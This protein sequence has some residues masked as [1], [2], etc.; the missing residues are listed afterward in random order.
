MITVG[1]IVFGVACLL[2]AF[3]L[4]LPIA[5]RLNLPYTVALALLGVIL[6]FVLLQAS[7]PLVQGDLFTSL[8]MLRL[9]ADG[10]LFVFLPPLLFA[11]GLNIDVRRMLDEIGPIILLAVIAVVLCTVI[12][13]VGVVY[14]SGF[15]LVV[16]LLLGAIVATTDSAAVLAIFK[17]L[18]VP[19]RLLVL[20]EGESLFNDAAAIALYTVLFTTLTSPVQP[21]LVDGLVTFFIGMI[22]G[23]LVGY[24]LAKAI[25]V[26]IGFMHNVVMAEVTLTVALAYLTYYIA[27]SYVGV[28]GVIAVVTASVSFAIEGRTRLSPGAWNVLQ[29]LWRILDF[30]AT[31]LIFILAA[32][33]V[34]TVLIAFRPEDIWTLIMVFAT[35]LASRY[36]V[37]Y[38]MIPG[39]GWFGISEPI[40]GAYKKVLWWGGLRG[41]VT[42]ALALAVS[43]HP[44]IAPEIGRFI[45]VAATGYV[46]ITLFFQAPTLRSLMRFLNLDK[47]SDKERQVKA[48]VLEVSRLHVRDQVKTIADEI[49]LK[50]PLPASSQEQEVEPSKDFMM[51]E[52]DRLQVALLAVATREGELYFEYLQKGIVSRRILEILRAH[53]GRVSDAAKTSG[54][55]GYQTTAIEDLNWSWKP[56]LALWAQRRFGVK[57]ELARL[58]AER[59]EAFLIIDIALH[60]LSKF[61]DTT[62]CE[63]LGPTTADQIKQVIDGRLEAVNGALDAVSLQFPSFTHGLRSRYLERVALGFEEVQYRKQLAQSV[64]S[65]EVF[66]DLEEDRRARLRTLEV[67]PQ[68]DLGLKLSQ[69][70]SQVSLFSELNDKALA[71]VARQLKPRLALPDECII[72]T[73]QA[74]ACM[75]FIA[76]GNVCVELPEG[77]VRLSSG[78]FFGEMALLS[79][80]PRNADVLA[81]GYCHLLV[82]DRRDFRRLCRDNAKLASHIEDVASKRRERDRAMGMSYV[83]EAPG[84]KAIKD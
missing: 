48:R 79:K 50:T 36:A 7:D 51:A 61:A 49:G 17:D 59:F 1:S 22:G 73:G 42:I 52:E 57:A 62:I 63:L 69:M 6:G 65:S 56:R 2:A 11:A 43:E 47:L 33:I 10:Y 34:P 35:T 4:L 82:L 78:D 68:L 32:M 16:C 37:L 81:D 21:T 24:I 18:G 60:E 72:R 26:A 15:P 8:Q 53:A 66:E 45:L 13:G 25:A 44:L 5:R 76:S 77:P 64:I 41:A 23:A 9:P 84:E 29:G 12:V 38:G 46:L 14:V 70:L 80:Q 30:W 31:S 55:N 54:L 27:E 74:G 67:R 20:V 39:L 19:K 58:L 75:Y 3:S 71:D 83:D 40:S 28:S